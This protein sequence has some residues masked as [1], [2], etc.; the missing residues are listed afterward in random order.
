MK[1]VLMILYGNLEKD[2]RVLKEKTS[3]EKAG[4]NVD[5][6]SLSLVDTPDNP[7]SIFPQNR[8]GFSY[9][10]FIWK[11][12][13]QIISSMQPYDVYHAHDLPTLKS[14]HFATR[15]HGG[16]IVFDAHEYFPYMARY[17]KKFFQR[18]YWLLFQKRWVRNIS[19]FITVNESLGAELKTQIKNLPD[20]VIIYNCPYHDEIPKSNLLREKLGLDHFKILL[21]YEGYLM[22]GRGLEILI[23]SMKILPENYHLVFLADGEEKDELKRLSS[24]HDID[25]RIHFHEMVPNEMLLE[26]MTGADLG[27]FP[28]PDNC[29][30]HHYSLPNKVFE[31]MHAKLPQVATDLPEIRKLYQKNNVGMTFINGDVKSLANSIREICENREILER[32]KNNTRDICIQFSWQE[33]DKKLIRLYEDLLG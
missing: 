2:Q 6:V 4:F 26:Y 10:N 8:T 14:A 33:Q 19:G 3:L 5:V 17:N 12:C 27:L 7:Y 30:N 31:Y 21:L 25:K 20:P 1:K 9:Y 23:E 28:Y 29:L 22:K 11:S 15:K 24:Q 13:E 32:M 16:K 18:N